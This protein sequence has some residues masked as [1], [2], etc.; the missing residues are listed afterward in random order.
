MSW[1]CDKVVVMKDNRII[2]EGS[3]RNVITEETMDE[4][5]QDVCSVRSFG[6]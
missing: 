2:K 4:I 3:S 1:F 5:Y 6:G